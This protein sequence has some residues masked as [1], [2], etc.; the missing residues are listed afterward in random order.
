MPVHISHADPV[1]ALEHH[2]TVVPL[3]PGPLLHRLG[4]PVHEKHVVD[5][6]PS[7]IPVGPRMDLPGMPVGRISFF[8]EVLPGAPGHETLEKPQRPGRF[9]DHGERDACPVNGGKGGAVGRPPFLTGTGSVRISPEMTGV[10]IVRD[11]SAGHDPYDFIRRTCVILTVSA[12][13]SGPRKKLRPAFDLRISRGSRDTDPAVRIRIGERRQS[14]L[15]QIVAAECGFRPDLRDGR[16]GR[17]KD[18]GPQN[19]EHSQ[20]C[21]KIDQRE[22]ALFSRFFHL[23]EFAIFLSPAERIRT[24]PRSSFSFSSVNENE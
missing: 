24:V 16:T 1:Q 21:R 23:Q 11:P 18:Q 22:A 13:F 9:L 12:F 7:R 10:Q 15:S 4:M 17:K 6:F 2:R 20:Y 3:F 14:D 5:P 19:G 8:P